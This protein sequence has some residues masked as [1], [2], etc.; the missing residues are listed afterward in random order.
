M[1]ANKYVFLTTNLTSFEALGS[2]D[3]EII[4]PIVGE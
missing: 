4:W 3:I 2:G 1:L